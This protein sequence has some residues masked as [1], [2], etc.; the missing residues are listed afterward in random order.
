MKTIGIVT[1]FN[2]FHDGHRYLIDNAKKSQDADFVI[3]IMSGN[4]MQ[5][6]YP[7]LFDKWQRAKRAVE[8]GVNLVLELPLVFSCA[9]AGQ[10]AYGGVNI[11]E[12]LG[13]VDVLAFGSESGNLKQLKKTVD[14]ITKIDIDYT[15]ELKE[16]LSKGYSYPAARSKLIASIEPDF[17][18]SILSEPNNILALE[19]LRHVDTLDA[20]TIKRIGKGHVET[21]SDIRRIWK[22][23][24]P[25]KTA[26][27][28][29][30]Y[31]D[32][33]RSKLL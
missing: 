3:A 31:F 14:L 8:G 10:F 18:D 11:L 1:E 33:V 21:A 26:E 17:D 7:A 23:D 16:I 19:Y 27:F 32:L 13:I 29:Q 20:Y 6:G 30:R 28:E 24:N 25:Q 5:R 4:F 15:D 2:P 9:S 22:E 12:K